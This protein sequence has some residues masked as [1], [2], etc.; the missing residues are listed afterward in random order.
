MNNKTSIFLSV[1]VVFLALALTV[2]AAETKSKLT[3]PTP[4]YRNSSATDVTISAVFTYKQKPLDPKLTPAQQ[5]VRDF[6]NA[7]PQVLKLE[8]AMSGTVGLETREYTN[9]LRY[10]FWRYGDLRFH[11]VS[12]DMK[13]WDFSQSPPEDVLPNLKWITA[14]TY[15]GVKPWQG[16]KCHVYQ[17]NEWTAWVDVEKLFPLCLD[18][19]VMQVVYSYAPPPDPPLRLP[20]KMQDGLKK[21]RRVMMGAEE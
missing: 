19:A 4:L 11:R 7:S 9:N 2:T 15:R 12:Q 20:D 17:N 14:S 13:T 6:F 3:P 18:S 1:S 8:I 5:K 16:R 21:I 10:E